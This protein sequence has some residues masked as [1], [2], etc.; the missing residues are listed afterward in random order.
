MFIKHC[1]LSDLWLI[2]EVARVSGAGSPVILGKLKVKENLLYRRD[3]I[4]GGVGGNWREL[5]I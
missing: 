5:F 1:Y 4:V 3:G 2:C